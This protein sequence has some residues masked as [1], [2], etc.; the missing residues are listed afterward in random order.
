MMT[1]NLLVIYWSTKWVKG[2]NWLNWIKSW[3][4]KGTINCADK[5]SVRPQNASNG[6]QQWLISHLLIAAI[7][8]SPR[9]Q[10]VIQ[11]CYQLQF[12]IIFHDEIG[13]F[14]STQVTKKIKIRSIHGFHVTIKPQKVSFNWDP[15][16]T[17]CLYV[18]G[19]LWFRVYCHIYILFEDAVWHLIHCQLFALAFASW[20]NWPFLGI[21][22]IFS[23]QNLQV[24]W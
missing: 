5:L 3:S 17:V 11:F 18:W 8:P 23:H 14:R 13:L 2:Y 12:P 22:I 4:T 19:D 6:N 9:L 24:I 21:D 10:S 16:V 7:T 15:I 20:T 1:H